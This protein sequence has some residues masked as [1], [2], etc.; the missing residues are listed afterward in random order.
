MYVR[1]SRSNRNR[2]PVVLVGRLCICALAGHSVEDGDFK[3]PGLVVCIF[4][5]MSHSARVTQPASP[6]VSSHDKYRD[7]TQMFYWLL[8][9][10]PFV[11]MLDSYIRKLTLVAALVHKAR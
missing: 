10:T 3:V 2:Y 6:E 1:R 9:Q 4:L 7:W 8:L 11:S 5:V